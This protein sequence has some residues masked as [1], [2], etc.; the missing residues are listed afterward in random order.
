MAAK[1]ILMACALAMVFGS[2]GCQHW[3]ERHYP[4]PAQAPAYAPA[5]QPCQS[6]VSYAPPPPPTWNGGGA[7]SGAMS[8]TCVPQR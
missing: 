3:C 2:V 5:C 4:C 7:P 1:R 6:P 8:C